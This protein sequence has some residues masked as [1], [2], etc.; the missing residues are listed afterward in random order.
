MGDGERRP[1]GGGDLGRLRTSTDEI[2]H[3]RDPK[4]F[5]QD[6]H[7][8]I[9]IAHCEGTH[10][11]LPGW[12]TQYTR[13]GEVAR[14]VTIWGEVQGDPLEEEHGPVGH[15]RGEAARERRERPRLARLTHNRLRH[16]G[17]KEQGRRSKRAR[18]V[19]G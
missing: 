12:A 11:P 6:E 10:W 17:N 14:V 2:T 16:E 4:F 18:T 13:Q 9:L 7:G 5:A 19:R 15:P 1:H 8:T 3:A